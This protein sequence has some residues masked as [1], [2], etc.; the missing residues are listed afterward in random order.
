M[1]PQNIYAVAGMPIVI[2]I[3]HVCA[4]GLFYALFTTHLEMFRGIKQIYIIY[5]NVF[6]KE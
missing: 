1:I 6:F 3:C 4:S 5:K 2:T